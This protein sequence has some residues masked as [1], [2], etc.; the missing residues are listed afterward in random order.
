MSTNQVNKLI[1]IKINRQLAQL[2]LFYLSKDM[3]LVN[4]IA[5][6]TYLWMEMA[7]QGQVSLVVERVK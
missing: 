2:Y 7:E 5:Y 4:M 1:E 3:N 6:L